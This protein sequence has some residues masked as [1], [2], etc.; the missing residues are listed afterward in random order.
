LSDRT[1]HLEEI[2]RILQQQFSTRSWDLSLP[3]G[4]GNE[5]Y[6]AISANNSLFI[7]LGIHIER[8]FEVSSAGL[9][10]PVF[11]S[12]LLEDGTS[13]IIQPYISGKK[14]D[15]K[16]Y[17]QHLESFASSIKKIHTNTNLKH[18]LPLINIESYR[19]VGLLSLSAIQEKWNKYRSLV[20]EEAGFVDE[21][22]D[23]IR[24]QLES[25]QGSGLVASHNDICNSNW[26]LSTDGR[27]YLIDL[28]SMSLDDPALDVGAILW[29]YYPPELRHEFLE[30]AGYPDNK[31]F[32]MR[33]QIRMA[34]HC[35][36]IELPRSN[37]F[38]QF[39]AQKFGE[40]LIDF[41]AVLDGK[42]NPQGYD[43]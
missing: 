11:I 39:D 36:N 6:L 13:F 3:A 19:E 9:T 7:K 5:T 8:Y 41:K 40:N 37:S 18:L 10:P 16:D 22:L 2:K 24:Q 31:E 33:M 34:M 27:I 4:R 26:L 25:F 14:P 35:L 20:P 23:Q 32:S 21:S 15:R 1:H 38:D 30:T 28:D 29:W 43:L 12:G 17:R 42:D